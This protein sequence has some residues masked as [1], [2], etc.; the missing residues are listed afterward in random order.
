[1]RVCLFDIDGTLIHTAGAG[2]LALREA[3][4]AVFNSDA[5]ATEIVTTGRTDRAIVEELFSR[6]DIEPTESNWREYLAAYL[7]KLPQA[8]GEC[9][10]RVLTGIPELLRM[11]AERSDITV[12]LLTGNSHEGA[13]HK[14]L[15][16]Q[17]YGHFAFGG[18]GGEHT[19][20][21]DVA[22]SALQEVHARLGGSVAGERITVIGDTPLDVRCARAIGARAVA[23][24]S[25]THSADALQD[26][27]PD[28]L[29]ENF[30]DPHPLLRFLEQD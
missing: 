25:G 11:L 1:M 5:G 28:L 27:A 3:M 7:E 29:I 21:D 19:N 26:S 22:R 13:R 4:L 20:R 6:H 23:V 15:H 8:L 2:L 30:A 18:F 17:L 9:P 14:L 12:G 10:G 16:Y 24:A